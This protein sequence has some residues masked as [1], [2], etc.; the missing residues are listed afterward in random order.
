MRRGYYGWDEAELPKAALEARLA[1]L[2]AGMRAGGL[3]ALAVY[4]NIARP[5]AVSW[6]TGFTPYWS[7]G[8]LFVPPEGPVVLA[9][10]LSKRVGEWMRAVTPVGDIVNT[11]KP[12]DYCAQRL[13]GPG[14]KRLGV[15]ELDMFPAGQAAELLEAAPHVE[16]VDAAGL[17]QAARLQRDGAE[18]AL[19]A[20]AAVIAKE[21]LAGIDAT[22]DRDACGLAGAV[23]KAMREARA[24]DVQIT[25]APD[26]ASDTRFVRVDRVENVG[27]GFAIRAS[28]AYKS[29]WVRRTRSIAIDATLAARFAA[30]ESAMDG[31]IARH[32]PMR[33]LEAQIGAAF[34][35]MPGASITRWTLEDCRGSYPLEIVA[36]EGNSNAVAGACSVLTVHAALEGAQW[37]ATR[38]L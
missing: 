7:E 9:T 17:F 22:P 34:A 12:A 6:L 29:T 33:P 13:A 31:L 30:L 37:V 32:D 14:A 4:T 38:P 8:L 18:R 36:R 16:L 19:F 11:P 25:L 35:A 1:R 23:E 26:L 21:A 10:A 2:Q 24:E 27:A 20:H 3:D 28:L 5:A 15:P